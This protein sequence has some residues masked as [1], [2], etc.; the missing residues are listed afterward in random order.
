MIFPDKPN[1]FYHF[2]ELDDREVY[3]EKEIYVIRFV[4]FHCSGFDQHVR[5]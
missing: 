5:C 1:E 3:Y 4:P 2:R